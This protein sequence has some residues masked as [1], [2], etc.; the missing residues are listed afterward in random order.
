MHDSE[1]IKSKEDLR[2]RWHDR[3][4]LLDADISCGTRWDLLLDRLFKL[5]DPLLEGHME[6][7]EEELFSVVQ[8]EEKFGTLRV[9]T[10]GRQPQEIDGMIKMAESM[11]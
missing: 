11:S 5:L 9:Y 10:P 2:S 6:E 8:V 7:P 1:E 4:P 3:S